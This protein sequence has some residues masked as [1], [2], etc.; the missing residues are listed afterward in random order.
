MLD[1]PM[2][3]A[4]AV[5]CG[6]QLALQILEQPYPNES[7]SLGIILEEVR[8]DDWLFLKAQTQ[9]WPLHWFWLEVDNDA[10]F[11][12]SSPHSTVPVYLTAVQEQIRVDWDPRQL[13]STIRP[14]LNWDA[15][16]Y[17]LTTFE[18]PYANETLLAD[19]YHLASGYR[20][21]IALKQTNEQWGFTRPASVAPAYPRT[22][23]LE[24]NPLNTFESLL[25]SVSSR[26]SGALPHVAAGLSGGLDSALVCAALTMEG[27][28]VDSY[29]ILVPG[30]GRVTQ[31]ERRDEIIAHFNLNDNVDPIALGYTPWEGDGFVLPWE[32]LYYEPFE[33]LYTRAAAT[34]HK[35]FC[36]GLGGNDLLAPYWSELTDKGEHERSIFSGKQPTL[37]VLL[38][39]RVRDGHEERT[40]RLNGDLPRAFV[41]RGVLDSMAGMAAQTLRHG[42]WPAHPLVAP[43]VVRYA[44]SLPLAWRENR[45]LMRELLGYWGGSRKVTHPEHSESFEEMCAFAMRNC[46]SFSRLLRAPHLADAGLVEPSQIEKAFDTWRH[47]H[48]PSSAA[49]PLVAIAALEKMLTAIEISRSS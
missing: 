32:E 49:L 31:S 41:Q 44:H 46:A 20:A 37:P 45:R 34:G 24:A 42:L 23:R 27:Y 30:A 11:I 16:A 10:L 1:H 22:L 13:L 26:I 9:G 28:S 21:N 5:C 7:D 17:F 14:V 15:A 3:S 6:N 18:Q 48:E 12:E 2:V 39:A 40:R 36:T 33:R 47:S 19:L 38:S 25:C 4:R 43:E 29:G 35:L 8:E